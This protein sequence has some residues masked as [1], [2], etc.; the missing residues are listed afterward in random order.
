MVYNVVEGMSMEVFQTCDYEICNDGSELVTSELQE[1]VDLVSKT[2]G[3][4][5]INRGKYLV[6]SIFLKSNM[7]VEFEKGSELIA[8]VNENEYP[9]MN[10]RVAGI[11]M[12]WYVAVLNIIE[13]SNVKVY[14]HGVIN[15]NGQY[16]WNK[17]WGIDKLGGMR[18]EYDAKG[19]RAFTDYDCMRPRNLLVS[20][21]SHIEVSGIN[22][23]M[24]G[25]WNIHV[26][27]SNDVII[28]ECIVD[29]G[30]F[31]SP[32]TDGIDIDSSHD[33]VVSNCNLSCH[34]DS[35]CIKSGR[36]GNGYEVGSACYD[37][38]IQ[39]CNIKQGMGVTIGSEVSGGVH[40]INISNINFVGTDCGIRIKSSKARKGYIRDIN[41]TNISMHNVKYGFNFFLDWNPQY[42][43]LELPNDFEGTV[44]VSWRRLMQEVPNSLSKT[45]VYNLMFKN[46]TCTY[47]E[48]YSQC[49]RLFHLIGYEDVPIC[50]IS[51]INLVANCK[52]YG[53]IKNVKDIQM[54][55]CQIEYEY[56]YNSKFDEYDN[57]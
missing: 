9:I 11:E 20:N 48:N 49:N 3:K 46:I 26:L 16:W 14:G 17:Y 39:D 56:A 33:I 25:F 52:E 24:S 30:D 10:T 12:D 19:L 45:K 55:N 5:I 37:I 50:D 1:L 22:S 41:V 29:A 8:T 36:D 44:P 47:D 43:K 53:V 7:E 18:K 23:I 4:L 2:R 40:D 57:R 34:D 13:C 27:Y 38:T 54:K 15:G 51:F 6:S 21:S 31:E 35:I 42:N 32:S 28:N